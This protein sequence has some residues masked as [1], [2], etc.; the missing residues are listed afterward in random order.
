MPDFNDLADR[1]LTD[2]SRADWREADLIRAAGN[3]RGRARLAMTTAT[4]AVV[5]V[6]AVLLLANATLPRGGSQGAGPAP[7]QTVTP[8]RTVAQS[9]PVT[10]SPTV[11]PSRTAEPTRQGTIPPGA[12]LTAADLRPTFSGLD[13]PFAQPYSANPFMACGPDGLPDGQQYTD[14]AGA[15]FSGGDGA[16]RGGEAILRFE[17]GAA[18][19]T[20]TAISQLVAGACAGPFQVLRRDLGGDESILITSSD[21][22]TVV[23]QAAHGM[24]I[25]FGFERRGDYLVWVTLVDEASKSGQADLAAT[26]TIHA[27]QR[28]CTAVTC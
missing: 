26:L 11:P 17:P 25:Y 5:A 6:V 24:A 23:P 7:S 22:S 27:A 1:L 21:G 2:M 16:L 10:P 9:P 13:S 4:V 15:Q 19:Q 20:M 14:A 28:A 3:R 18:H 8:S 12:L